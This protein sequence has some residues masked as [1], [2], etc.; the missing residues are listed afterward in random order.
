[1]FEGVWSESETLM[2]NAKPRMEITRKGYRVLDVS[3]HATH[4]GYHA[5]RLPW[6]CP[7][8]RRHGFWGHI[9]L[10][11]DSVTLSDRPSTRPASI[12]LS[13]NIDRFAEMEMLLID[14]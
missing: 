6:T 10:A 14:L 9:K 5:H 3:H 1:M 7:A 2:A 4:G 13:S 8:F 11:D 12:L